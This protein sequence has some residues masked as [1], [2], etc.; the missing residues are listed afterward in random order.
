M[1]PPDNGEDVDDPGEIHLPK[2]PHDDGDEILKVLLVNDVASK[3][4]L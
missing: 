4:G 2:R 3:L 1:E